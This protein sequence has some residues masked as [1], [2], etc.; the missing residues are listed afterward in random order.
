MEVFILKVNM[1]NKKFQRL[2]HVQLDLAILIVKVKAQIGDRLHWKNTLRILC[3]RDWGFHA[4]SIFFCNILVLPSCNSDSW[5]SYTLKCFY[6]CVGERWKSEFSLEEQEKDCFEVC[7]VGLVVGENYI[8]CLVV[9]VTF[10]GFE[11]GMGSSG[12]SFKVI[13]WGGNASRK[14]GQFLWESGVL[15]M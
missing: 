2:C 13:I 5:R 7:F 9:V 14:D 11:G 4:R 6:W 1:L 3:L 10:M 12:E 8:W 15:I